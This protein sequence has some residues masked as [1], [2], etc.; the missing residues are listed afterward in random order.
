MEQRL[1]NR[2]NALQTIAAAGVAGLAAGSEGG[3][4][5]LLASPIEQD[6]KK[7]S[8]DSPGW[9]DC[10]S[11]IWTRDIKRFPLANGQTLDDLAP[12]S[13]THEELMA[14]AEPL[15]VSRVVLIQHRPY[16]GYDNSYCISA[17]KQR[18]DAFRVVGMIDE[19]LPD[20]PQ[21]M[22]KLL[23]QHVTGFRITPRVRPKTWLKTAGM[24]EMWKT[25]AAT[26][27]AM[28]CLIDAKDLEPV[29]AMCQRFPETPVVI[30]HFARIGVDGTIR[31]SDVKKLCRLARHPLTTV[32]ISAFYALGKKEPP[33]DDLIPMIRALLD[34]FGPDR[35]MWGTD[36]PYQIND[37]NSYASSLALMSRLDIS[38]GD[39]DWL[40]KKTAKGV[41]HF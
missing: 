5:R 8:D 7:K 16:H 15:G 4:S 19:A 23:K 20:V 35:L 12:P 34:A 24:A 39:R 38:D 1:V 21:R 36:C 26:G 11:H 13:F 3:G 37:K 41:F 22:R 18:P 30:D 29:D 14:I 2:R 32:K 9:V 27:Q 28:C 31:D 33:H 17:A 25:G 10:H 6:K 40:M